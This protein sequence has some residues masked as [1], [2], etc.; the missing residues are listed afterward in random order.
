MIKTLKFLQANL[1]KSRNVQHALHNDDTLQDFIAIL[2][3]EPNCLSGKELDMPYSTS[4][5]G[6]SLAGSFLYLGASRR[7]SSAAAG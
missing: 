7:S 1:N 6:R 3:Q 5:G 2:G 4:S